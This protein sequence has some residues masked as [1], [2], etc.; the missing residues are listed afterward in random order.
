LKRKGDRLSDLVMRAGGLTPRA[1]P[2][3]IRFVRALDKAGRINVDLTAALKDTTSR[4]NIIL[5]PGDSVYVP[6]YLPSVRVSGAVNSPGSILYK[7]G[8]GFGDYIDG[9]GGFSYLA[10]K[11]RA[12]VRYANGTVKTRHKFLFFRSSPKPGPGSEVLVPVKDTSF[13]SASRVALWGAIAQILA[14]TVAILVV[15]TKL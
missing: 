6:E 2:N 10:D 12:S 7:N 3:G 11:G 9:A 15:A 4:D 1:Y 8:A 5:Q 14:S 13:S